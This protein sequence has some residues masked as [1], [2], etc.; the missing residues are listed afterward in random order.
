MNNYSKLLTINNS[1]RFAVP[2]QPIEALCLDCIMS[3]FS[4]LTPGINSN[5]VSTSV[6]SLLTLKS[7]WGHKEMP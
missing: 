1:L 6:N 5:M 4:A 2:H 3:L 7:L